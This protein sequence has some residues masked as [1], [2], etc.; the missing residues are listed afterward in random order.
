MQVIRESTRDE[1]LTYVKPRMQPS[2]ARNFSACVE[3]VLRGEPGWAVV[4]SRVHMAIE[5]R[6]SGGLSLCYSVPGVLVDQVAMGFHYLNE[7]KL[8]SLIF[9]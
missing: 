7:E 1:I 5:N 8:S 3:L 6:H 2:C 4:S 9:L